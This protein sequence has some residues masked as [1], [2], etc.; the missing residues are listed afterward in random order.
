MI[1]TE[2]LSL[3]RELRNAILGARLRFSEH[4][5]KMH[6]RLHRHQIDKIEHDLKQLRGDVCEQCR[7][8]DSVRAV[9]HPN[10]EEPFALLCLSCRYGLGLKPWRDEQLEE[11]PP[12]RHN[13][14]D[15]TRD[16]IR[17]ARPYEFTDDGPTDEAMAL[18]A[19]A[20]SRFAHWP[21]RSSKSKNNHV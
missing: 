17:R 8:D 12:E 3:H 4:A 11:T 14:L 9:A 16:L 13:R 18:F 6:E 7:G 10:S 20:L 5:P 21:R 15:L 2:I 1:E 19:D